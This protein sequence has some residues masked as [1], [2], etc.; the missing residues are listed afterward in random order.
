M[1]HRIHGGCRF[2]RPNPERPTVLKTLFSGEFHRAFTCVYIVFR[3]KFRT[4]L[5]D[6]TLAPT[7]NREMKSTTNN[8]HYSVAKPVVLCCSGSYSLRRASYALFFGISK[9]YR[10]GRNRVQ[11]CTLWTMM[12]LLCSFRGDI[13]ISRYTPNIVETNQIFQFIES[14]RPNFWTLE[15]YFCRELVPEIIFI[16]TLPWCHSCSGRLFSARF[17]D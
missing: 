10:Y 11:W 15:S 17:G 16:T 2:R 8:I 1:K 12:I 4:F 13:I 7:A 3:L 5:W 9:R 6:F 14:R